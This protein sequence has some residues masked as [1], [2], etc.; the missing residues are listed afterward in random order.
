PEDRTRDGEP[1]RLPA[2]GRGRGRGRDDHRLRRREAV[3]L[4]LLEEE[5]AGTQGD[6]RI[7]GA[8]AVECARREV[9]RTAELA[10]PAVAFEPPKLPLA[11]GVAHTAQRTSA[12]GAA[13]PSRAAVRALAAVTAAATLAVRRRPVVLHPAV[14][15]TPVGASPA[16]LA[17]ALVGHGARVPAV[18][19]IS[20]RLLPSAGRRCGRFHADAEHQTTGEARS[21]GR[22][23]ALGE[24]AL[25]L[26]REDAHAT[27]R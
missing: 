3:G 12:V 16:I 10:P 21:P 17:R 8:D 23:P 26:D 20:C 14:A 19:P 1:R 4:R 25:A 5:L 15:G 2:R 18:R 7:V 9:G 11:I 27:P 13:I 6:R 22:P 24:P